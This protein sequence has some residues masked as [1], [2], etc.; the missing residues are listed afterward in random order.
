MDRKKIEIIAAI[1]VIIALIVVL[2]LVLKK[3]SEETGT[4]QPGGGQ[5]ATERV[6]DRVSE[7]DSRTKESPPDIVARTFVERFGSYSTDIDYTNVEDVMSL[8]TAGLTSRL[9]TLLADARTTPETG[10]YGV[11]THVITVDMVEETEETATLEITTQ[12]QETFDNP[13]NTSV[14]Y[15]DILVELTKSG[16]RWLVSNFTW[17]E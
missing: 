4:N 3:P 2:V 13:S 9:S 1:L 6:I 10:F 16:N 17:V 5:Q 14:R 7:V 8:A 12:R 15:Q 11:S